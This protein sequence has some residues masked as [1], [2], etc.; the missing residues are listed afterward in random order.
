MEMF[1]KKV[2]KGFILVNKETQ[3]EAINKLG[4]IEQCEF[5]GQMDYQTAFMLAGT[6]MR[7]VKNESLVKEGYMPILTYTVD[8]DGKIRFGVGSVKINDEETTEEAKA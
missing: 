2:K 4:T 5:I 3:K 7:F 8:A 1:T 6:L